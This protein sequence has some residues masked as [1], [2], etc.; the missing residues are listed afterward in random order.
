MAVLAVQWRQW[1]TNLVTGFGRH[2]C[3]TAEDGVMKTGS[4]EGVL[5]TPGLAQALWGDESGVRRRLQG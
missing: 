4:E 5:L 1:V 2:G 3:I